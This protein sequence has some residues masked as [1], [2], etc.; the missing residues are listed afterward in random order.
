MGVGTRPKGP[1]GMRGRSPRPWNIT[2]S[3]SSASG[4]ASPST[5]SATHIPS[6]T[7]ER[8]WMPG[9]SGGRSSPSRG[10]PVGASGVA[11]PWVRAVA[12]SSPAMLT[13]S[14]E[15]GQRT[16]VAG[17]PQPAARRSV[18]A[19]DALATKGDHMGRG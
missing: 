7:N 16:S 6:N 19:T 11:P 8:A 4:G 13:P 3:G 10:K 15:A 1:P 12:L 5:T 2:T 18:A 9:A 17:A 14:G